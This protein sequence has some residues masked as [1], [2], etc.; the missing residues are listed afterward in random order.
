MA[1]ITSD[2]IIKGR[3]ATIVNNLI[4]NKVY[5]EG[6]EVFIDACLLGIYHGKRS[7]MDTSTNDVVNI[8]R[9]IWDKRADLEN[10]LFVFLQHE[11]VLN[12]QPLETAE[13]FNINLNSVD[14]RELLQE[15]KEYAYYGIEQLA[16]EY[17]ALGNDFK[18][19]MLIQHVEEN[20][21]EREDEINKRVDDY[22]SEIIQVTDDQQEV[23]SLINSVN[24]NTGGS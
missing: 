22:L 1:I 17:S 20:M 12:N 7:E 23:E 6:Y 13:V 24:I 10:S 16:E 14:E 3:H 11:K 18:N 21:L 5:R 2:I 9:T 15:L 8:S 4:Y 19:D